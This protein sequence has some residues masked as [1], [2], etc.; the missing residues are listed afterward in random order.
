MWKE[1]KKTSPSVISWK[2]N[3]LGNYRLFFYYSYS[4]SLIQTLFEETGDEPGHSPKYYGS[5]I[6]GYVEWINEIGSTPYYP[7]FPYET[8]ANYTY[9][10]VG[11]GIIDGYEM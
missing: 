1:Y 2:Q 8:L 4:I 3:N 10:N 6:G 11:W 9:Y 7:S 5:E